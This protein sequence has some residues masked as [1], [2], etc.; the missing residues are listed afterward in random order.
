[1]FVNVESGD[2]GIRPSINPQ[3]TASDGTYRWDVAEGT[4]RVVVTKRGYWRAI[5]R[6]VAVPPPVLDLHVAM[7]RRPG[8]APEGP[9]NCGEPPQIDSTP[10]CVIRPANAWVR[11]REIRKVVFFLDGQRFRTVRRSDKKGRFGVRIN[12]KQLSPGKHRVRA[13]VIFRRSAHRRPATVR[14]VLRRCIRNPPPKRIETNH[15]PTCKPFL[16]FVLG[17]NIKV[18]RYTLDGRTLHSVRI[19]DWD[20]R[21]G[22]SIDPRELRDGRHTLAA[23]IVFVKKSGL[24]ART[25]KLPFRGC[26]SS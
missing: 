14:L 8:T 15:R 19:A 10:G 7:K 3:R 18:V 26:K 5:S 9:H 23:R 24:A 4:Y 11:G 25:V 20:G 16:G 2:E 22:V 13:R 6:A 12:R 21:Y 1:M 17:D